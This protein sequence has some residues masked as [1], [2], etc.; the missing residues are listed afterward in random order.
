M[1]RPTTHYMATRPD[2]TVP[3]TDPYQARYF[4]AQ[5]ETIPTVNLAE[6]VGQA[7]D[8]PSPGA[9]WYDDRPF[10]YF[11]M[12]TRPGEVLERV[13]WPA[14]LFV[15]EPLGEVGNWGGAHYPYWRMSHQLEVVEETDIWR[16][17]GHRG[18]RVLDVIDR[19]LPDLARQWAAEWAADPDGTRRRY[20]AW[21]ERRSDTRVLDQWVYWKA[22][23]SR[24]SAAAKTAESLARTAGT[25]AARE[26]GA[27]E[28]ATTAIATRAW[29]LA[30]AELLHDRLRRSDY[31]KQLRDLLRGS[32]HLVTTSTGTLIGTAAPKGT[33]PKR[34]IPITVSRTGSPA[35]GRPRS[36][37]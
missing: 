16:A 9:K 7:V 2:G 4:E 24:R 36:T 18:E 37:G 23:Y 22:C 8:H 26:A 14:R 30:A 11:H 31:E 32:P 20:D 3:P 27:D 28:E 5:G 10:S 12:Y 33:P 21:A 34:G 1:K 15:V 35:K 19:Q 29:C 17:F 13:E 6:H 25:K